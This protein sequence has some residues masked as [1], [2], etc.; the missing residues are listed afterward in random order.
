[1]GGK[2]LGLLRRFL[3]LLER[4]GGSGFGSALSWLVLFGVG[5]VICGRG[6]W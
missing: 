1:V 5:Y 4:W 3:G 6:G 2:I